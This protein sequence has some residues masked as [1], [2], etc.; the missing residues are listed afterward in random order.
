LSTGVQSPLQRAGVS[1]TTDRKGNANSAL[2]LD[3][4]YYVYIPDVPQQVNTTLSAWIKRSQL[5]PDA[6]IISANGKGPRIDQNTYAFRGLMHTGILLPDVYSNPF[7]DQAWH[8]VVVTYDGNYL[9]LY[10]DGVLQG[11]T[12]YS[13]S[14]PKE[15]FYY[16]IG[17]MF[18]G[19]WKGCVD[20]L[21]FYSR[22]LTAK[23]VIALYK[24]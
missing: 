9:K 12:S 21:R 4:N 1:Y 18:G 7:I 14:F 17:A 6:T 22:T 16:L 15:N 3:G 13:A 11:T 5:Y 10:V 23:D 19:Y 2:K 20:D 24:L 8:H